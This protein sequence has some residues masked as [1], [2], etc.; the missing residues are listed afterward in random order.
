MDYNLKEKVNLSMDIDENINNIT[1]AI[2]YAAEQAIP[3]KVA[4]IRP[5]EQPWTTCH[6]KNLIRTRKRTHK[7]FK[8]HLMPTFG[9]SIR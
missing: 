8:E 7:I 9:K 5:A 2:M 6:I 1:E 4:T 3:N